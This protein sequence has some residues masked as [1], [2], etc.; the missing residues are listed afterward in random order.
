M[1]LPL[2]VLDRN[3]GGRVSII[4]GEGRAGALVGSVF[5]LTSP[6]SPHTPDADMAPCLGITSVEQFGGALGSAL[7]VPGSLFAS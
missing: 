5:D 6:P 7:L 3:G 4:I 1:Q 2:P